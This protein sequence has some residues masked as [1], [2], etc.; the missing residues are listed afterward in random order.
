MNPF[1]KSSEAHFCSVVSKTNGEDPI[2][3]AG[4]YD[5]W[6]VL[7]T[8]PPWIE[9]FWREIPALQPMLA[10]AKQRM[11]RDGLKMRPFAIASDREY[12]Q[13]IP[14]GWMRLIHYRRPGLF[15]ARFEK[16]EYILP[17]EQVSNLAIALLNNN[18]QQL[19]AFQKF[20]QET[21]HIRDLLVCTHGNVDVAC[22]R[23]GYP[24]YKQLRSEYAPA[25]PDN[26]RVWQCSHFGGHRFAPTLIDLPEGRYWG[27]LE[28]GMLD[29][30]VWQQGDVGTLRSF[31]R[32]W[33]GLTQIE[34]I[35]ECEIWMQ[36][37]WSWLNYQKKGKI[38]DMDRE[39]R[40]WA[41]IQLD[42]TDSQQNISGQYTARVEVS[43]TVDTM[44]ESGDEQTTHLKQYQVRHLVKK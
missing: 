28:P 19:A 33:A 8:P 34:Q 32:G 31:Y 24:I 22:S 35:A 41:D 30:L 7:E 44:G 27:H 14:Q 5:Q 40:E 37:G 23:F 3:S 12:S 38:L 29:T 20:R 1:T 17:K 15:F 39:N 9:E 2:G 42:F 21:N 25:S 4:N 13:N 10:V 6:F 36:E 26:L 18:Q 11:E 16:Q 43:H